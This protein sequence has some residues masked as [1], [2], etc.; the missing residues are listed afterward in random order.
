[1]D[2]TA[3]AFV[4]GISSGYVNILYITWLQTYVP[5]YLMGRIAQVCA[6]LPAWG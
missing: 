4:M 2:E 6:C 3:A 5:Q 1:M